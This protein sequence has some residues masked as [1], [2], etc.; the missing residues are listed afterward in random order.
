MYGQFFLD[1]LKEHYIT[2]QTYED[3]GVTYKSLVPITE[4]IDLESRLYIR[5]ENAQEIIQK[6][7]TNNYI[8]EA[9][10]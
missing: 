7:L 4:K 1:Y 8:Q 10:E 5:K 9:A 2:L 3:N 6:L